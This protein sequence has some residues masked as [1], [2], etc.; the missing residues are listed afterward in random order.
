[1]GSRIIFEWDIETVDPETGDILDHDHDERLAPLLERHAGETNIRLVLVRD[2]GNDVDG[3]LCRSWAYVVDNALPAFFTD[4]GDS[5]VAQVP[6]RFHTEL[7]AW[8]T[9]P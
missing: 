8:R 4:A 9:K 6:A 5:D 3:L 7:N 2:R 1:M